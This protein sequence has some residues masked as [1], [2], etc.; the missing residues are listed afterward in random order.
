[1]VEEFFFRGYLINRF[2]E[3]LGKYKGCFLSSFLFGLAH[4]ISQL[5][6]QGW[7]AW[8][9]ALMFGLQTFIGGVIFGLIFIAA[10]NIWPGVII[11]IST[12]M[13]LNRILQLINFM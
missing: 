4:I 9:A 8:N 2:S 7:D 12:N 13:Y 6:Q 3:W 1:M 10:G 5:A 11:H